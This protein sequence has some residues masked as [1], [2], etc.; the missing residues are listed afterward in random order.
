MIPTR[1][2]ISFAAVD[3]YFQETNLQLLLWC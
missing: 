1:S 2:A 3:L